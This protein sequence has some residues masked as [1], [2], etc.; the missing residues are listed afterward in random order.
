MCVCVGREG[1][2]ELGVRLVWCAG[3]A[4]LAGIVWVLWEA[5]K[6]RYLHTTK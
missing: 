5:G 3:W 6:R 1:G 4:W 2:G